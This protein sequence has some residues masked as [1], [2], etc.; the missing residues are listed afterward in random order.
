MSISTRQP[1]TRTALDAAVSTGSPGVLPRTLVAHQWLRQIDQR[2]R[3]R[4]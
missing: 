3:A 2:G 1:Q 4:D